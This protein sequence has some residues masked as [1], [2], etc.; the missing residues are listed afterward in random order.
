MRPLSR[1][2]QMRL[3]VEAWQALGKPKLAHATGRE[4]DFPF[5]HLIFFPV[6]VGL[7]TETISKTTTV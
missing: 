3:S 1:I 6:D 2:G 5:L 4:V 7:T